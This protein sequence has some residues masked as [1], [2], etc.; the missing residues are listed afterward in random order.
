MYCSGT[1]PGRKTSATGFSSRQNSLA[2][3]NPSS[4]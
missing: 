3:G 1:A 4:A 2:M